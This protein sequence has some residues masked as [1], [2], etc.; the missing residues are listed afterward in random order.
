MGLA[1]FSTP[2][3]CELFRDLLLVL[4]DCGILN[5]T[6]KPD[7]DD[8]YLC[9]AYCYWSRSRTS[10]TGKADSTRVKLSRSRTSG[11]GKADS[12]RVKV[13]TLLCVHVAF[14]S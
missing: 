5:P 2:M 3:M 10:G 14:A 4:A 8:G 11:T 9:R 7:F 13:G 12:T 1:R 6:I